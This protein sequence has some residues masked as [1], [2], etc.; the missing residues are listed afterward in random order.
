MIHWKARRL[1][2]QVLDGTLAAHVEGEVREHAEGCRSCTRILAEF[3]TC[4]LLLGQLPTSLVPAH[5][6]AGLE[7]RLY[8]LSRWVVV[9]E[10]T[11]TE[12]LGMSALGAGAAAALFALVLT[13]QA[14][15]PADS[16]GPG[17]PITLAAV[18]PIA[19]VSLIPT[20]VARWR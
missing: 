9:P 13:G 16:A 4:E 8:A 12:R 15:A 2:P 6:P 5:A 19:D 14:Y 17:Q 20:G 7:D 10:P 3:E 18:L 1:L 11:W